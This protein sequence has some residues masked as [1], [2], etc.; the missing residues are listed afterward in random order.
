MNK[1]NPE[2][3]NKKHLSDLIVRQQSLLVQISAAQREIMELEQE[4]RVCERMLDSGV[5]TIEVK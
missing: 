1:N 4:I 5:E 2:E 3:K